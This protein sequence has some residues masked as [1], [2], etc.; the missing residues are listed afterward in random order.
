MTTKDLLDT[1]TSCKFYQ[2]YDKITKEKSES[3]IERKS[4]ID[5][6]S[7]Q[8]VKNQ[9]CIKY[10]IFSFLSALAISLIFVIPLLVVHA[11]Y[12]KAALLGIPA[13]LVMS[14]SWMIPVWW[15][16]DK[17]RALFMAI[18]MGSSPLRLGAGLLWFSICC[19]IPDIDS[20]VLALFMMFEWLVFGAIEIGMFN[21]MGKKIASTSQLQP[22]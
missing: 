22:N 14:Y 19:S 7:R 3:S 9:I 6:S 5:W 1:F 8:S 16:W 10:C 17:D 18:T 2:K 11:P 13:L 15:A 12:G 21:E 4:S 20:G